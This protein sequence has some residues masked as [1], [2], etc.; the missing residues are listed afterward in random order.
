MKNLLI[1]ANWKSNMMKFEAKDWLVE[2]SSLELAENL[3]VVIFSP[4]T[5]LDNLS[6]YIKVNSMPFKIGAQDISPYDNGPYTGEISAK[7]IKEFA[8]YVLIGHSERRANFGETDE[9]INK[10]IEKSL[11]EGLSAIVCVSSLNQARSLTS[12]DFTIAYEPLDAIGTGNPENPKAVLELVRQIKKI[13]DLPIIYGGSVSP[14]NI[15]EYSSI[16]NIS[17]ALVGGNSLN[18]EV[19][20]S[21]IKNVH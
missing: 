20:S 10:K 7:Q 21:L 5:L 3:E 16:E 4:F 12:G 13:R 14:E 8:D 1:A 2:V 6:G 9:M 18:P 17:G 19:F 11:G 15:K